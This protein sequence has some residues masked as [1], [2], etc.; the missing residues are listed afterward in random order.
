MSS[1]PKTKGTCEFLGKSSKLEVFK[2]LSTDI[3][4]HFN[5]VF[6]Y[7]IFCRLFKIKTGCEIVVSS[8]SVGNGIP[9]VNESLNLS[10]RS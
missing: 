7:S 6:D 3:M 2:K 8:P 10:G 4:N 1:H 9:I 5:S